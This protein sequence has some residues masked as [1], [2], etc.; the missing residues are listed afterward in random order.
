MKA[1]QKDEK[2]KDSEKEIKERKRSEHILSKVI[3]LV[4]FVAKQKLL[5][6]S[7]KKPLFVIPKLQE[8]SVKLQFVL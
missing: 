8:K 1:V 4:Y 5:V 2:S 7:T 3:S 6:P